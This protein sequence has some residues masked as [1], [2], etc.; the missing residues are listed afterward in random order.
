[1]MPMFERNVLMP[2]SDKNISA[3]LLNITTNLLLMQ[4]SPDLFNVIDEKWLLKTILHVVL[5]YR[6]S[7][8]EGDKTKQ[9]FDTLA[10][11]IL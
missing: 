8:K 10:M 9:L 6:R 3:L 7:A 5:E 11:S 1:M 4:R 2:K